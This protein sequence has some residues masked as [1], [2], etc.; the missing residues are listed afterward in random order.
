MIAMTCLIFLYMHKKTTNERAA[1]TNIMTANARYAFLLLFVLE[2][3]SM[4]LLAV[5]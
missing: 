3:F 2:P 1:K 4:S 5:R